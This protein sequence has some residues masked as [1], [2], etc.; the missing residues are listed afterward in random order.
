MGNWR[1][2]SRKPMLLISQAVSDG[3]VK[4][5]QETKTIASMSVTRTSPERSASRMTSG[6]RALASAS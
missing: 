2:S 5:V 3:M 1:V 4:P 6:T